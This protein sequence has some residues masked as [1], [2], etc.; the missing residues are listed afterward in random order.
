MEAFEAFID[1]IKLRLQKPLPGLET[2][3]RLAPITR[4]NDLK[5]MESPDNARKSA[6]LALFYPQNGDIGLLLI[7]RAVDDTVHSGQISFP[8]GKKEKSDTNLRE[9]AL[10]ETFEEIGISSADISIIGSLSKLYIPPSNFDV[11]PFVG[12][13]S[14]QPKL[15]TNY[16]VESVLKVPVSELT[17]TDSIQYKTVKGRDGQLYEVPCYFVQDEIIWG[18]TA[19]MLSELTAIISE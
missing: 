5:K 13:I 10:R 6:V 11:Y 15:S 7:K 8:G 17:G 9:T 3:L 14:S 16:E 12:Y 18:A 4:L 19:M 2:Q 1:Q